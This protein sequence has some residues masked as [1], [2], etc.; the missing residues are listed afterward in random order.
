MMMNLFLGGAAF[1]AFRLNALKAK[2][3]DSARLLYVVWAENLSQKDLGVLKNLLNAEILQKS[4]VNP[5][6]FLIAPRIGTISP[7]ASKATEIA[8]RSGLK[9]QR[10][11]KLILFEGK[12]FDAADQLHDLMTESVLRSFDEIPQ[13]FENLEPAPFFEIENNANSLEA[14]NQRLGL[15]L[16]AEEKEYLFNIFKAKTATRLMRN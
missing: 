7:W 5:Q 13:L 4:T 3:I 1:S 2:N 8:E 11:E 14:A 9:V 15:A 10:I 16:N 12:K 6:F